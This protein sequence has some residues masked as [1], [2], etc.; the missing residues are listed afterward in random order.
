MKRVYRQRELHIKRLKEEVLEK[1]VK[2]DVKEPRQVNLAQNQGR[3]LAQKVRKDQAYC[4]L[5]QSL[6]RQYLNNRAYLK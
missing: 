4:P 5:I 6:I 2:K 1:E 3:N